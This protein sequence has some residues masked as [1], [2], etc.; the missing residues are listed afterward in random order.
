MRTLSNACYFLVICFCLSS[1]AWSQNASG[2]EDRI[3]F[4]ARQFRFKLEPGESFRFTLPKVDSPIRIE[5]SRRSADGSFSK[6]LQYSE[7]MWALVNVDRKAGQ[8][9]W[10]GTD[11]GGGVRASNSLTGQY[12]IAI[13]WSDAP[14]D[15]LATLSVANAG[16]RILSVTQIAD[17]G[18]MAGLYLVRMYY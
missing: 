7:L 1:L 9:T 3:A 10:I 14:P 15:G 5:I 13:I 11:S 2:S 17:Q 18:K 4:R 16:A 8:I 6:G 12:P